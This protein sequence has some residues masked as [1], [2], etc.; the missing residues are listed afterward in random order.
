[1]KK[2]I[3]FFLILSIPALSS[4]E[5]KKLTKSQKESW[6][7]PRDIK[8]IEKAAEK[9]RPIDYL[10]KISQDKLKY[11]RMYGCP[12]VI[13]VWNCMDGA[14]GRKLEEWIYYGPAKYIYFYA[15]DGTLRKEATLTDLDK[16]SIDGKVEVGMDKEQVKRAK[17]M[18]SHVENLA[19]N[20]GADEKW[21]YNSL[22]VWFEGDKAVRIQR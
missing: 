3:V 18:P 12:D 8:K 20:D 11:F 14:T 19:G 16:L 15:E 7:E 1:M 21:T 10:G 4:A 5:Y 9:N 17:G 2:V 6:I 22:Y 13:G